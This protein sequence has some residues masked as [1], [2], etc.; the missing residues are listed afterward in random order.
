MLHNGYDVYNENYHV[1]A[2]GKACAE[3][4]SAYTFPKILKDMHMKSQ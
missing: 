1:I 3:I 4:F 2:V